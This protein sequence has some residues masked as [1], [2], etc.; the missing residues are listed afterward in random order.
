MHGT[1]GDVSS[2][3]IMVYPISFQ[4]KLIALWV[5]QGSVTVDLYLLHKGKPIFMDTKHITETFID[6]LKLKEPLE[7]QISIEEHFLHER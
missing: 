5:L 1:K 6:N 3:E 7:E 2:M 4:D